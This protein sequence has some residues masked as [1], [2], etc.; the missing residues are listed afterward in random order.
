[1]AIPKDR[2]AI[3][4][5][6]ILY[7]TCDLSSPL[8]HHAS[9]ILAVQVSLLKQIPSPP[10]LLLADAAEEDCCPCIL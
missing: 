5:P 9:Q 6:I 2:G 10:K 3:E 4:S 8:C 7:G 1:M